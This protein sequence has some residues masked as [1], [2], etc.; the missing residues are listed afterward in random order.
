MHVTFLAESKDEGIFVGHV[1]RI[2]WVSNACN[3]LANFVDYLIL[4]EHV[5][6]IVWVSNAFNVFGRK[7]RLY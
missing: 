5:A 6:G 4:V 2:K 7:Q 1:T 3:L